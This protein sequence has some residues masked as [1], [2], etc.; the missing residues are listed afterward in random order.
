MQFSLS[1]LI[2]IF[3]NQ[4]HLS[5]WFQISF[6]IFDMN[7]LKFLPFCLVNVCEGNKSEYQNCNPYFGTK[8]LRKCVYNDLDVYAILKVVNFMKNSLK[9]LPTIENE[10]TF[11]LMLFIDIWSKTIN[12]LI[13]N[14]WS[15]TRIVA[16]R[17][18]FSVCYHDLQIFIFLR[19][20]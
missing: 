7:Y 4:Y 5:G 10:Y 2:Y 12:I 3:L 8:L 9:G 6:L 1:I 17:N 13:S 16:S 19:M 15:L 20:I 11:R 14:G 18:V